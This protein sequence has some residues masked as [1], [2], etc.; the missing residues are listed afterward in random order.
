MIKVIVIIMLCFFWLVGMFVIFSLGIEL[1]K[2]LID[3]R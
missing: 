1:I 3:R 2:E